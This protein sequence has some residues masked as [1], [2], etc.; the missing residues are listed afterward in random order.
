MVKVWT[1]G[2]VLIA[3]VIGAYGALFLKKGAEKLHRS[4]HSLLCNWKIFLGILLYG[5]SS[6]FFI[7]AL[8]FEKLSILYPITSL[9]YVWIALL[10]NK[11]LKERHNVYKWVGISLI[12]LGVT[13]VA[14]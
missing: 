11:Y 6:I 1:F 8:K 7:I 14:Q 5:I 13:L 3:T 9:G 2:M 12:I 10:S 4:I